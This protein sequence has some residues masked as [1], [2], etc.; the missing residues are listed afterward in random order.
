MPGGKRSELGRFGEERAA[1]YLEGKGYQILAR[2][3][4]NWAGEVDLVARDGGTT[5]FVEVRTRRG[6]SLGTP[7]ESITREK[8]RR[9]VRVAQAYLQDRGAL[10]RDW[11]VDVVALEL[12]G[13]R[14]S[15]RHHVSAVTEGGGHAL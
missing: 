12:D 11:R 13:G 7:E 8:A 15:L 4:R 3:V 14:V 6:R 2:N 9:L 10:E 1:S 5:V